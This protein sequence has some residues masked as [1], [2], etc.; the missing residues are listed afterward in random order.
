MSTL[1]TDAIRKHFPILSR[2]VRGD[3]PLVY[4]DSGATSQRPEVV[5]EAEKE[6][7]L[8]SFAPVHRGAYQ[9]AEEAT[10]A[11]EDAREAIANF[12][13]V[14]DAEIAFTKNATE[15][16]NLVAFTFAD[17]RSEDLCVGEGDTVVIS[18]LEHHANLVPWQELCEKTGATL[19]WYRTTDDGRIDLDSLEL[20]ES[21]K[22]VAVTHQSNV[23]GAVVDVHE[24]VRRAR[25]VDALVVLDACQS[26]PHMPVDFRELDVDFAAF[27][28]HKMCGPSGVGVLYGKPDL[29]AKLPPFLTGGSMIE[30]VKMEKTTFAEPPQRFEAGTQMTSQV[31]GLGAAV[32]F[33]QEIGMDEIHAHEQELTKYCLEKLSAIP[34]VQIAGPL[35]TENRGGAVSFVVDGVHPHDLGQVLDDRGVCVRVGHHCAWPAHRSLG[36]QS[37]ARA[38][39]Y[40]YNTTEEIDALADGIV[41]AQ[42]FFGV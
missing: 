15:A 1:D 37:T 36:M 23:T 25:A 10:D 8:N 21:V 30:V 2:T 20:D 17:P 9:L 6:F 19:K 29:L 12:V 42:E 3:N 35:D 41:H 18:E 16:L 33:L 11:Y 31:V 40:L 27:S 22:V 39:F 24:V 28:G 5:W 13:G 4:L 7:V 38:S 26:V 34:G 14:D 32:K